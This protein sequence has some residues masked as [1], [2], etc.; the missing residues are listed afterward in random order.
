[1]E[2]HCQKVCYQPQVQFK[3]LNSKMMINCRG[4]KRSDAKLGS[5]FWYIVLCYL[6][7]V[8]K[9]QAFAKLEDQLI[10]DLRLVALSPLLLTFLFLLT[11]SSP[12]IL[13][14]L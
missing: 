9:S 14:C 2:K 11:R 8:K 13:K 12:T 10:C 5:K 6:K 3:S 1:M 7:I 4:E